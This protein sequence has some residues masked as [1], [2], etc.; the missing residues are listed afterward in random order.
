M[1]QIL[2]AIM[3][4]KTKDHMLSWVHVERVSKPGS[5]R[6]VWRISD[7]GQIRNLT[8]TSS[9][10]AIMDEAVKIYRPALERLAKR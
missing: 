4:K 3:T 2:F 9:S 10:A 8:T 5:R 6:E 7:G 1:E